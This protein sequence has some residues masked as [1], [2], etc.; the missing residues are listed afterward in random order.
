[1]SILGLYDEVHSI[2]VGL[3][4]SGLDSETC[5]TIDNSLDQGQRAHTVQWSGY[6]VLRNLVS[7]S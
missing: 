1:M 5:E 6:R 7:E 2:A 4:G 3:C